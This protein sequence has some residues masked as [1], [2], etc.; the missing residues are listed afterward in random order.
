[1]KMP[2]PSSRGSAASSPERSIQRTRQGMTKLLVAN[3]PLAAIKSTNIATVKSRQP[4][5][6]STGTPTVALQITVRSDTQDKADHL[7][8]VYQAF[9]GAKQQAAEAIIIK[10]GSNITN[11][12]LKIANGS[13]YSNVDDYQL[14]D[15]ITAISQSANHPNTSDILVHLF[16]IINCAFNFCKMVIANVELLHAKATCMH[17]YSIA[18]DNTQLTFVLLANIDSGVSKDWGREFCPTIQ[19]ISHVYTYNYTHDNTSFTFMLHK[20]TRADAVRKLTD[21]PSPSPGTAQA[22]SKQVSYL[23]ALLQQQQHGTD[24]SEYASAVQSGSN[25]SSDKTCHGCHRNGTHTN[26]RGHGSRH[27]NDHGEGRKC[28]KSRQH[29]LNPCQHCKAYKCRKPQQNRCFW[30]EKYKGYR[31]KWICDPSSRAMGALLLIGVYEDAG[32]CRIPLIQTKGQ[33]QPRNPSKKARQVLHQA[34]SVY[35]LPSIEKAIRWMHAVCGYPVKSIWLKAIQAGNFVGLPLLT[36][37]SINKYYPE[38]T[39]PPK[40]HLNQARKNVRSTKVQPPPLECHN[41]SQLRGCKAHNIFTHCMIATIFTHQTGKFPTCS[42]TGNNYL[43]I[44][45]DINSSAILIK[46]IKTH[47]DTELTRTYSR[48]MS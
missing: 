19:I 2:P 15:L 20:L 35:D 16:A 48:L 37:K 46:P 47:S 34:N 39:A 44:M 14:A 7:N 29:G 18:V 33:W 9:M 3:S 25:S 23:T 26:A 13:D 41:S 11:A 42:E 1:M 4:P 28:S 30:N 17:S 8:L 27:N 22:I 31:A 32:R 10:L 12:I 40:G 38:T 6:S 45:V 24:T 43:M 21:A 5:A 36:I